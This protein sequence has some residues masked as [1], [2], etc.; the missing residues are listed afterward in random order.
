MLN[1]IIDFI[2]HCDIHIGEFIIDYGVLVYLIIFGIIFVETGLVFM[3]FLPGDSLIFAAGSFAAINALN[4]FFLLIILIIAAVLGDT[5]NYFIGKNFSRKILQSKRLVKEE[6]LNKAKKFVDKYGGK[7]VFL[8]RFVPIIRTIVPFVAG[9][10]ELEYKKFFKYNL[11]G[12]ITWVFVCLTTG[13]FFGNIPV[14]KNNFSIFILAIIFISI[15]P[16]FIGLIRTKI[17]KKV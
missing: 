16:I 8:A 5:V 15:L 14:V 4:Y 6:N 11:I 12:G 1:T 9:S 3:P 7:A 2:I 13:Y 10:G 17:I